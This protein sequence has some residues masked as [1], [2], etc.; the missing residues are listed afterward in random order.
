MVRV[1][2]LVFSN[3]KER[4]QRQL[5]LDAP[6]GSVAVHHSRAVDGGITGFAPGHVG[7]VGSEIGHLPT[8]VVIVQ[9][10]HQADGLIVGMVRAHDVAIVLESLDERG[11]DGAVHISREFCYQPQQLH[12]LVR[13]EHLDEIVAAQKMLVLLPRALRHVCCVGEALLHPGNGELSLFLRQ[14]IMCL[15]QRRIQ[16]CVL[17]EAEDMLY[18]SFRRQ[19]H[20]GVQVTDKFEC[21]ILIA[22]FAVAAHLIPLRH[23]IDALQQPARRAFRRRVAPALGLLWLAEHL[24]PR[25]Q[26]FCVVLVVQEVAASTRL[27][28]MPSASERR[29]DGALVG[30]R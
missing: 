10:N 19:L 11:R 29:A 9:Q 7:A 23:Q 1:Y 5:V 4:D 3:E 22:L 16:I 21:L 24:M 20:E 26:A 2:L 14:H 25:P 17:D 18:I 13:S 12:H 8:L 28:P 6:Q 30:W 27:A 15:D